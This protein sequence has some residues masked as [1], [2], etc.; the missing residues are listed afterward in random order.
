[1]LSTTAQRAIR[2]RN[3]CYTVVGRDILN[4]KVVTE[5]GVFSKLQDGFL[6][7]GELNNLVIAYKTTSMNVGAS[8]HGPKINLSVFEKVSTIKHAPTK[9]VKSWIDD[10]PFKLSPAFQPMTRVSESQRFY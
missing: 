2:K 5:I 6:V 4:C 8:N 1:M 7:A 9:C 10:V 3:L